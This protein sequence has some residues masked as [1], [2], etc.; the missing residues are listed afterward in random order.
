L[1]IAFFAVI[2]DALRDVLGSHWSPVIEF[3]WE[4]L[5]SDIAAFAG[6]AA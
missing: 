1:F 6:P 5:L 4:N 2:W 3:A